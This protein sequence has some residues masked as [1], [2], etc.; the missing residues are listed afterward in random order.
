MLDAVKF[1]A[2]RGEGR[3]FLLLGSAQ[4]MVLRQVRETLAG[5][6]ALLDR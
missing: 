2:D 4:L 5:R 1:L 6:V 3:R